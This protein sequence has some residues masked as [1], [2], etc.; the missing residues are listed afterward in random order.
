MST[1]GRRLVWGLLA[2][3]ALA[4]VIL[5]DQRTTRWP[6]TGGDPVAVPLE[7]HV[8]VQLDS[9]GLEGC[10]W[11]TPPTRE[12]DAP[13]AQCGDRYDSELIVFARDRTRRYRVTL[14][15]GPN[16]RPTPTPAWAIPASRGP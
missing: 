6:P 1:L 8:V 5:F 16:R 12:G 11:L 7:R 14:A 10:R 13:V 9:A 4:G 15:T 3:L 2:A